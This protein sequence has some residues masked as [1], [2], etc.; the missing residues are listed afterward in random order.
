MN[1]TETQ[2][3]KM[4]LDVINEYN[5][6]PLST[7]DGW[8][9]NW[10]DF[11]FIELQKIAKYLTPIGTF[12]DIGTGRG[13]APRFVKKIKESVISFDSKSAAGS[14]AIENIKLANIQG[15]YCDMYNEK[16][17]LGDNSCDLVFFGDVIEHLLH[18]PKPV[19]LEFNRILSDQGVVIATTPNACR[20]TV[21]LKMLL[22]Y[23]NWANIYEFFDKDFHPG[24][25][26]EYT[27]DEFKRIFELT[28]FEIIEFVLYEENLRSEKLENFKDIKTQDRNWNKNK[29]DSLFGRMMKFL[30]LQITNIFPT[31]RSNMLI[32]A[33][34]K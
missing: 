27:I 8:I 15:E 18:S 3:K 10:S 22:G 6:T 5:K 21:R 19:L 29:Q 34:K 28:G 4:Y 13:I 26:H 33:R 14:S 16:L 9:Y 11:G 31:L 32:I 25:H 2:V 7:N 20:L 24:H 1:F 12:V 23:S 30:L 17:P